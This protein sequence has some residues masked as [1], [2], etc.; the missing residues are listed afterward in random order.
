MITKRKEGNVTRKEKKK[1]QLNLETR[2]L[3][4]YL[5]NSDS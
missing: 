5:S 2:F 1:I 3:F 4:I